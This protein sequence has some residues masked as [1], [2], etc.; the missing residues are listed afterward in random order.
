MNIELGAKPQGPLV[1]IRVLDLSSVI[2]GPLCGQI[3]GDLGAEVVKVEAPSGDSARRLGPPFG[4][5][6]QTAL[7]SNANRNKRS[8]TVDLKK[9]EGQALV[10]R[11][12][13]KSDVVLENFRPGVAERIGVGYEQLAADNPGLVYVSING[14]GPDGPYRDLPAYDLV[15]QAMSGIAERQRNGEAPALIHSIAADKIAAMTAAQG[16]L[17]ALVSRATTGRG[18]HVEVPMMDA[19]AAFLMPD[20]LEHRTFV[21]EDQGLPLDLNNIYRCWPTRDGHVAMLVLEDDQFQGLC[22]ALEREDLLSDERTSN[23]LARILNADALFAML[24]AEIAKFDTTTLVERARANGAPLAPVYDVE[25]FL[26][27]P[28]VEMMKLIQEIP[29]HGGEKIRVIAHPVRYSETP[30]KMRRLAPAPGE[31]TDEVLTEEGLG[32]EAIAALR[33][34]GVIA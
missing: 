25:A 6:G 4:A 31:H 22:R 13:A 28:H 24:G 30:V 19:F 21:G 20:V 26:A 17:A 15:I 23:V 9:S 7:F 10:R 18:Q 34:A 12:A 1:G 29:G 5:G 27:D 32:E 8:I 2:S 3:L 33:A 11:L 14:F 16:A